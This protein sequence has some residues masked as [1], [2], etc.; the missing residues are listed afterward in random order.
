MYC[1]FTE[2][3]PVLTSVQVAPCYS[4]KVIALLYIYRED[5]TRWR[6]DMNFIFKWQKKFYERA[7]QVS[8]MLFLP[9]EYKIHIFKPP[10]N[11]LFI[12]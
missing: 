10:C 9:R 6:E 7:Q 11:D 1:W 8:K 5:I 3:N 12:I 4:V 2:S